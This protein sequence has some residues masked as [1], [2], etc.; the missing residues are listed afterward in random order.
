MISLLL[1]VVGGSFKRRD[2]IR[3]IY[4]EHVHDALECGLL[5][6]SSEVWRY[7]LELSL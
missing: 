1:N 5:I 3:D 7:S 6:T 2:M 4:A